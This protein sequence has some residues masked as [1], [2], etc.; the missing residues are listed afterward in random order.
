MTNEK[1]KMTYGKSF[2]FHTVVNA[3]RHVTTDY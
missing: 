1:S 2:R 3:D